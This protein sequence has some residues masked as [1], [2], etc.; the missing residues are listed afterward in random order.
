MSNPHGITISKTVDTV[1]TQIHRYT[2][3]PQP[4][5]NVVLQATCDNN[6]ILIERIHDLDGRHVMRVPRAIAEEV[7]GLLHAIVEDLNA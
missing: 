5:E 1:E 7:C 3:D 4:A 6:D 2:A